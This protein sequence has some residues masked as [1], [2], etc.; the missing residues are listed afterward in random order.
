MT[1]NKRYDL[2]IRPP[3]FLNQPL[4]LQHQ[5]MKQYRRCNKVMTIHSAPFLLAMRHS[6]ICSINEVPSVSK[7]SVAI[8]NQM[9]DRLNRRAYPDPPSPTAEHSA[10][11]IPQRH[12]DRERKNRGNRR[13][14]V[15]FSSTS[16]TSGG[17]PHIYNTKPFVQVCAN[18][19]LLWLLCLVLL[20]NSKFWRDFGV[21]TAQGQT[22]K[23]GNGSG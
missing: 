5:T 17:R 12:A 7:R 13:G 8:D 11:S 21:A 14:L 15:N 10:D 16:S 20:Q 6:R 23:A 9:Q 4:Y 22:A 18:W 19:C 3:F 1:A 2:G